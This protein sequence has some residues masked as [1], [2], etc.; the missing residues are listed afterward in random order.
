ML[1]KLFVSCNMKRCYW[2]YWS[3]LRMVDEAKWWPVISQSSLYIYLK[4]HCLNQHY[5]CILMLTLLH[6]RFIHQVLMKAL[7]FRSNDLQN[8]PC[9]TSADRQLCLCIASALLSFSSQ[10][11]GQQ[12][13]LQNLH[14]LLMESTGINNLH[15]WYLCFHLNYL[16]I[17]SSFNMHWEMMN[18]WIDI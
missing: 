10:R 1:W 14:Q 3:A 5:L 4:R 12:I 9:R 6:N 16:Y 18:W 11:E 2:S 7:F 8:V 13:V 15:T 17:Y